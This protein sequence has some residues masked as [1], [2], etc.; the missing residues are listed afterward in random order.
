MQEADQ[1]RLVDALVFAL[2]AH[3]DQMR[4]GTRVPYVSHLFQVA[5]LVLEAGGDTDQ[6]LAGLL[7]DSI[8]DCDEVDAAV[9]RARFGD[10]V[11]RIVEVCTDV[12]PGDRS[13]AKS[14][15]GVRKTR[16]L[17]R[18]EAAD[19]RAR[20][21]AACDKLHNLRSLVAD[22][23]AHGAAT[24]ERFTARPEQTRW[25]YESAH[26][27]LRGALPDALRIDFDVQLDAL[28]GFVA[29]AETPAASGSRGRGGEPD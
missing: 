29:R 1:L 12:E 19:E 20:L 9:L 24:L 16:Y 17:E 6:A 8:E 11:T 7:H 15:W 27:R 25:Y 21:V 10:E 22:L 3:A 28:R 5:G 23:R 26:A 18:L 14:D 2:R 4:K 13:D